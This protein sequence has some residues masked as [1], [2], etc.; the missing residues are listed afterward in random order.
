MDWVKEFRRLHD[1]NNQ[2]IVK[3]IYK[4]TSK[5]DLQDILLKYLEKEREL[6]PLIVKL[7]NELLEL[8]TKH[9]NIVREIEILKR[10][11]EVRDK[12]K[13]GLKNELP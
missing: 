13:E 1:L 5:S 7:Q 9:T 10:K 12:Q 6:N 3:D 11:L 2:S 4:D 8:S